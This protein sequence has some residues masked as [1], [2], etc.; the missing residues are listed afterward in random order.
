MQIRT[1]RG[2]CTG[3]ED[4]LTLFGRAGLLQDFDRHRHKR[5]DEPPGLRF[6]K[7]QLAIIS[8]GHDSLLCR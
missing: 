8:A 6:V 1:Y 5:C 3:P 2:A 4:S 7:A